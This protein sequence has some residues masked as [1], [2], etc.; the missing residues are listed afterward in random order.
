MMDADAAP[1]IFFPTHP[2]G[3]GPYHVRIAGVSCSTNLMRHPLAAPSV[4]LNVALG[5]IAASVLSRSG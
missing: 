2:S 3:G 5:R 1:R 4:A